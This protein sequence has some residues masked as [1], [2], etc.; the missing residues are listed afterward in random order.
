MDRHGARG[1]AGPTGQCEEPDTE[2]R[3]ALSCNDCGTDY[4]VDSTQ[5]NEGPECQLLDFEIHKSSKE[6]GA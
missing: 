1:G 6:E 3:A 2:H 4:W 5:T